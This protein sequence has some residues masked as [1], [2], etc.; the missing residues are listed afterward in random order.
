MS[1]W[2]GSNELVL[3]LLLLIRVLVVPLLLVRI[4][5]LLLLLALSIVW[6]VLIVLVLV[7]LVWVL[8]LVTLAVGNLLVTLLVG[9]VVVVDDVVVVESGRIGKLRLRLG[10]DASHLHGPMGSLVGRTRGG[11]DRAGTM[12]TNSSSTPTSDGFVVAVAQ[13]IESSLA[14]S[15]SLS[16]AH[17]KDGDKE[18]NDEDTGDS[19]D[20][21][22]CD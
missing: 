14:G 5:S 10:T 13:E 12:S 9:V 18:G 22:T 21:R 2:T 3:L 16:L 1:K 7:L 15:S 6:V 11:A 20:H 17:H 19:A 4:V 8:V